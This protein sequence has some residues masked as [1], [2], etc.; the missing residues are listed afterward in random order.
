MISHQLLGGKH[1]SAV[2]STQFWNSSNSEPS[3]SERFDGQ[4]ID[5][6]PENLRAIAIA[7]L[8]RLHEHTVRE[9]LIKR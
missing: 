5:D 9:T 6:L 8:D 2:V 1:Q 4:R 3:E 7:V